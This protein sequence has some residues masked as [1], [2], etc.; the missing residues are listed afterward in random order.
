MCAGAVSNC[1]F[2]SGFDG[3]FCEVALPYMHI[4]LALAELHRV[5]IPEAAKGDTAFSRLHVERIPPIIP[6]PKQSLFRFFFVL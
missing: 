3:V 6:K 5:L 4:P 1:R 2:L